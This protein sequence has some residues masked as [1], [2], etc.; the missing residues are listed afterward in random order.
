MVGPL[1]DAAAEHQQEVAF[2]VE[3][4]HAVSS[5]CR[6]CKNVARAIQR[7]PL[8]VAELSDARPF[9]ARLAAGLRGAGLQFAFAI[10]DSPAP[11]PD[12]NAPDAEHVDAAVYVISDVDVAGGGI[13]GDTSGA[14]CTGQLPSRFRRTGRAAAVAPRKQRPGRRRT[15]RVPRSP[16]PAPLP[17]GWWILPWPSSSALFQ[18]CCVWLPA[19]RGQDRPGWCVAR[20]GPWPGSVLR[21]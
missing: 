12:E 3:L 15:V 5:A 2:G 21:D 4:L 14:E 16:Q 6:R 18:W 8:R 11:G 9:Q 10:E 1:V 19:G 7:D 20:V 17:D 13:G